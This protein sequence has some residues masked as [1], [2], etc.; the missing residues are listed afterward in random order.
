MADKK[1]QQ[2]AAKI[3]KR[4]LRWAVPYKGLFLL[5]VLGNLVYACSQVGFAELM[6]YFIEALEGG[7]ARYVLLVPLAGF[8][9]AFVRGL[10]YF[11]GSFFIGS[12]GQGVVRDLR[13]ALFE[14]LILL[15]STFFDKY[16]SGHL[17]SKVSYDT[18]MV[19]VALTK[20][21]A[22]TIREGLTVIVLFGYMLYSNWKL[23]LIFL[24]IGPILGVVVSWIGKRMRRLSTN[25][26][27]SMGGITQITSEVVQGYRTVRT[28]GAE[29]FERNR[30]SETNNYNWRQQIKF[31]L[32]RS[33]TSPVTQTIVAAALSL[34][35][36]LVLVVREGQ[37]TSELIAYFTAAALLPKSL[38]ALGDVY[39]Q[40]QKGVAAGE[41]IFGLLDQREE[42]NSGVHEPDTVEGRISIENLS[43]SYPESDSLVLK[44][45]N[46]DIEA[47]QT[48]AL[49][50]K[51]GSGKTT[52][53][54]LL[55]RFYD[56]R[57][58]SIRLDGVLL[59]EY[60]LLS[61]RRQ[62]AAVHQHVTLFNTSIAENIAYGDSDNATRE[63]IQAAAKTA[64]A[65][66]FIDQLEQGYE[67]IVG[68]N[69]LMLSGGQRQRLAIARAVL[70]NAPV[71]ILDEATSALD[72]ESEQYIQ[73]A[74]EEIMVNR[75]TLVI[76]HRLSTIERADNIVVM[77]QGRIV[78]Q[79]THGDLL[80]LDGHYARL[81]AR[82]FEEDS[83]V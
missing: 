17:V 37:P 63:Q 33:L 7:S 5:S 1:S 73:S 24:A 30:F 11:T 46:L 23:T 72:N 18:S 15:P 9:L 67:T 31:V 35:M 4:L 50:G 71:V 26:Q 48:V 68:E 79:G 49:V 66:V 77:D 41:S 56:Y 82:N 12:L 62:I 80:A 2:N 60:S 27:H 16:S 45:I 19:T 21:V 59:R 74:M 69:A 61:L 75:T 47:G 38:R 39:G 25:I 70:R 58:G 36:Y 43:F 52:L 54:S 65:D 40:I 3:Y 64:H 22:T 6:R 83:S 14:K 13:R 78:E 81:H 51:S 44:D 57:E 42:R 20:A 10:G 76:A 29:E 53:A 28:H 32:T 34:V 8:G 55:L